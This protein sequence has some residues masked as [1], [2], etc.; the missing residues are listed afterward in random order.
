MAQGFCG[1]RAAARA[2]QSRKSFEPAASYMLG[3]G[4]QFLSIISILPAGES[5]VGV[6]ANSPW[7]DLPYAAW[8]DTCDTLILWTQIVGKV[9]IACTPLINHWWNATF[10]VTSRGLIAPAMPYRGR[11][12]DVIFDFAERRLRVEAS[13]GRAEVLALEPMTVAD[14]YA[15]FMAALRRLDIDVDIWTMPSEIE[16]A[17]PFEQDR[18]H[19]QYDRVYVDRFW[20]ALVQVNRVF[21]EFRGRFIGKAS[22]VH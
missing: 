7:P 21:T 19:R 3:L 17:I 2:I 1:E 8:H 6:S 16:N 20:Q 4:P 9:R 14:F 22:P 13:D 18:T 15:A 11:T 5:H 10:D 12:F